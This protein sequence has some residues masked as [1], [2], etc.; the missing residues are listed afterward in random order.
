MKIVELLGE[1]DPAS[2]VIFR[3]ELEQLAADFFSDNAVR[4]SY[5]LTR[6]TKI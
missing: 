5:L 6:A 3:Q 2:L 1:R 4:Q